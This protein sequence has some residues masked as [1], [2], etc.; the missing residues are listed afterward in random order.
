MSW[1]DFLRATTTLTSRDR[2]GLGLSG[3][4]GAEE[5]V[6]SALVHVMMHLGLSVRYLQRLL[7][8]LDQ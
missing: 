2:A 8:P 3:R 7:L 1:S 6:A 4:L 5:I